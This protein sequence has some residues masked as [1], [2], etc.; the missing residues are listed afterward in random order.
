MAQKDDLA[1]QIIAN[2]KSI[3]ERKDR[4]Q[5][6]LADVLEI[7]PAQYSRLEK[8]ERGLRAEEALLAARFLRVP[9]AALYR[10]EKP[11]EQP[12]AA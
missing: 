9:I 3:R 1:R 8:G 10:Q 2:L 4:T 5:K 6:E 7:D 12:E 11:Q